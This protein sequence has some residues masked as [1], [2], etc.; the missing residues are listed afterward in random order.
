M[1]CK[2]LW[3]LIFLTC[4]AMKPGAQSEEGRRDMPPCSLRPHALRRRVT[5]PAYST[6]LPAAQLGADSQEQG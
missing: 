2:D 1:K 6:S 4:C 5:A 3:T